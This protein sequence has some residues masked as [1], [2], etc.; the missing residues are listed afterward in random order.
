MFRQLATQISAKNYARLHTIAYVYIGV[1]A[2]NHC[3]LIYGFRQFCQR[4]G[5]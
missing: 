4:D 1:S 2:H 5:I 3:H